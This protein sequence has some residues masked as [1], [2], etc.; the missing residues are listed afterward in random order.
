[1]AGSLVTRKRTKVKTGCITCRIRK[2]KCDENKPSCKRCVDTGR[3]CDGY[4]SPFRLFTCQPETNAHAGGSA[5]SKP[6]RPTL[7]EITP[8]DIYLLNRYFSTKTMFDVQLGCSEEA[9]QCLQASL[10]D[11]TIRHALSSLRALREHLDTAGHVPTSV[12]QQNPSYDYGLQQYCMALGGLASN[13]SSPGSHGLKSALR[14]CQIFISIEQLRGNYAA[15]TRHILQGFRIMESY[16]ARPYLV[17]AKELAP[18]HH[19]QLPFVDV[20]LIKLFIA[21]CKF[22]D[23][24]ATVDTSGTTMP[25]SLIS[26]NRQPVESRDSRTL[27][28]DMRT[29]LT[30]IATST[31]AFLSKVSH[32]ESADNAL[33]LLPE[34]ASL[35]DSLE[36]W[37]LNLELAQTE[38]RPPGVELLSVSF[39]RFFHQILKVVLLGALDSSPDL[40]VELRTENDRLQGIASDLTENMKAY[41]KWS[42]IR[43]G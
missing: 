6:I 43:S 24:P 41:R 11:S 33:R 23:P 12:A 5:S 28:P 8:Q 14:C 16:R 38:I 35:L 20:F 1:M 4:E 7:D 29:E 25:V 37:R 36:S 21:P 30:K 19:E 2:V 15:M 31:L 40:Y 17:T 10:T 13:L 34:K 42:R 39:M 32:L 26:P 18:A 27:A 9:Q 3:T 22:A